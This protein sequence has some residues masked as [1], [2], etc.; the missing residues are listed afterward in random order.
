MA[1]FN[2]NAKDIK[3]KTN[4]LYESVKENAANAYYET[5][6]KAE[7][8]ASQVSTTAADLYDSS[9]DGL[10]KVED[11]ASNAMDSMTKSIRNQP[12]SAVLLAGAIG[13]LWAKFIK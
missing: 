12:L 3:D 13:Y 7:E 4:Q 8:L 1:N 2:D 6:P 9:K 5:K 10:N 11:Y